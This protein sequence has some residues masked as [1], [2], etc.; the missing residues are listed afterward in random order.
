MLLYF[1]VVS[2]F[3]CLSVL[4]AVPARV[5]FPAADSLVQQAT[6]TG[7][8]PGAVLWIG[9]RAE[10]GSPR[11]FGH[12][13]V[14]PAMR[15][16]LD[17]TIFDI[18]SLTKPVATSTA[19]MM[20]WENGKIELDAPV[21]KYLPVFQTTDDKARIT[22][23]HLLTHSAGLP[24]GG[25]YWGKTLSQT[26]ILNDIVKAPQKAAPGE[27]F[28]YSDFSFIT[29]GAVV[30]AVSGESLDQ[31]CRQR[32]FIP[33]GMKDTFFRKNQ[34][35]L[36]LKVLSRIAAT[37]SGDDTLETRGL[38]HDPTA[39]ALGG[40]AGHAGLF[41][42]AHDLARFC[43]MM[44]N[45]GEL[46]GHRLLQTETVKTWTSNQSPAFKGERA[47][48]WDMNS[49]YSIRGALS[50]R[51]F[52][53]TGFTGTSLWIDPESQTFIILLTNAVHAKPA[54][55]VVALRRAVSNAVAAELGLSPQ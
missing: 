6:E 33:L 16:M 43:Q 37:T 12:A 28:L 18:A 8:V 51:S 3:V 22:I 34:E 2:F 41:S 7:G 42:T 48:G 5:D 31:F 14:R 23:R 9:R 1:R 55:K 30:E 27:Q 20:L 44:L 38:V 19:I 13:A 10:S 46:Q 26:Q 35:T 4:L 45:G 53:H 47:L 21:A 40:V 36:D 11:A 15:P 17:D 50:L 39:R 32:I 29:L 25:A 24:A 52:G 49:A 54:T